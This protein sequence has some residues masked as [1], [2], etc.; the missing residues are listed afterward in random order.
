MKISVDNHVCVGSGQCVNAAPG[1]FTQ[2]EDTGLVVV[3]QPDAPEAER[4]KAELA[5]LSCPV[6]A[7]HISG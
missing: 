6:R 4:E 1:L 7:V 3:L 5:E 2:D